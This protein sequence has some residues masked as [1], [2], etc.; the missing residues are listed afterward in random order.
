MALKQARSQKAY[1]KALSLMP[2]GVNS[3][4]RAF[5]A[6]GGTPFFADHGEGPYLYDIDGNRYIDYL[7][8]WG[9]LIWGHAHPEIVRAVTEAAARGMSFGVPTEWETRMAELVISLVPSIEVVRMV[10]SGTE[11]TMSALRLARAYTGRPVIVKFE[12]CYHGHADSLLVKAGSGVATFGLPD[13]PG[14]PEATAKTT[15]TAPYNDLAAVESLFAAHGERI[16]AVIVEPVAG[17]MGCVLPEPGFLAGLRALTERYGALLIF[18]EVMTG[19]RVALGGA[20]A[21]FSVRPDLTT[22][23]KVIGAGMPVG[24]YG[25]RREIMSLIAPDGPVYQAGTLSGNPLAMAAGWTSLSMLAAAGDA[26]YE[27]MERYGQALVDAFVALGRRKGIPTFGV[28][29]GGMFGLFFHE[30]PVTDYA[31]AKACDTR[32]YARFFHAMLEEGVALAPSQLEAGF[33]SAVHTEAELAETVAA[34][35]RAFAR[36]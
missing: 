12:G 30:G 3:P 2:G 32:M 5:R 26:L 23:G 36:L 19:F 9:P 25:G 16:A 17:N 29:V 24:A 20:Q 1:E 8:S 6:V 35:E 33:L 11:A 7:M 4:V 18:D 13:S 28:A 27:R 31:A 22:L 14:V 34:L 15:L 10:N 21:R